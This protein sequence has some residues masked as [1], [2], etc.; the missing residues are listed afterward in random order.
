V[1]V[2]TSAGTI[3]AQAPSGQKSG[4]QDPQNAPAAPQ[5]PGTPQQPTFATTVTVIETAP[6]P[7]VGLPIEKIPA[8]VQTLSL[9]THLRAH[10]T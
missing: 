6:L 9:Y 10:E 1:A 3:H 2:A 8:P 7:G 4:S 5:P